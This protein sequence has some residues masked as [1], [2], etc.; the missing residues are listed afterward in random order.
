MM[1]KD[2]KIEELSG[3][4]IKIFTKKNF[5][6]KGIVDGVYDGFVEINDEVSK[7][8]RLIHLSNISE[9]EVLE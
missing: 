9:L 4:R 1:I 3:K 8:K 2:K 7:S 5:I 6:F